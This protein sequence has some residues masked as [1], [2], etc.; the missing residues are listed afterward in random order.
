M[1]EPF[2]PY[3]NWLRITIFGKKFQVPERTLCCAVFIR[4]PG[5]HPLRALLL[6]MIGHYALSPSVFSDDDY[7]RR[8]AP[9]A[10]S[11]SCRYGSQRNEPGADWCLRSNLPSDATVLQ[12]APSGYDRRGEYA[13]PKSQ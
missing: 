11:S 10:N 2:L 7:P 6:E 8:N 13:I 9:P 5:N 1:S 3:E 12:L 4:Q